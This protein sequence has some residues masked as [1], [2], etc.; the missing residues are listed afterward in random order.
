MPFKA[1][2]FHK[3]EIYRVIFNMVAII[4][5]SGSIIDYSY[6]EKYFNIAKSIICVDGGAKHLRN[7]ELVPDVLIGDLDSIQKEDLEYLNSLNVRIIKYPSEKNMTDTE[8]AVDFAVESGYTEIIIIGGIGSRLDHSLANI[9]L[10]KQMLSRGIKGMIVNEHNEIMLVK[11][12]IFV[13][14][15]EGYK[16][17]LLP[18]TNVVEGITTKGLYYELNCEDIEMGSSRGVSNEFLDETAEITIKKG[19]LMV[20]KSRD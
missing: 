18:L 2:L 5:C 9:F 4:V 17:T 16:L 11:D 6:H 3:Q 19:L 13:M 1:F 15:E 12:R 14:R 10:L 20:I 7:L 8:I